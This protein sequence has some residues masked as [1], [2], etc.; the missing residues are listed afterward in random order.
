[1]ANLPLRYPTVL[2]DWGDTVMRDDPDSLVPMVEWQTVEP[3]EG[4]AG[5]LEYL[6]SSGRQVTLATSAAISDENQIRAALARVGLDRYFSRI[7]CF[8]NMHIPKGEAFYREV[9]SSLGIPATEAL[10]V[11]DTFDKDVLAANA[12]GLFAIWFN[13]DSEEFQ[14]ANSHTTVHSMRELQAFFETLDGK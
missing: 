12:V 14:E 10:M 6:R 7:Y 5:V 3:I 9:L 4:V 2:F 8:K 1:M 11:G 13:P